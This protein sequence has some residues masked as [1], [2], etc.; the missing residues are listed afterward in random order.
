VNAVLHFSAKVYPAAL[1][2]RAQPYLDRLASPRPALEASVKVMRDRVREEFDGRQWFAP[3]GATVGWAPMVP[4][5]TKSGE[6]PPLIGTG[7]YPAAWQGVGPGAITQLTANSATIGVSGSVFKQ[8]GVLRGGTGPN[9]TTGPTLIRARKLT[10]GKRNWKGPQR[11]AMFWAILNLYGV[12]LSLD[13]LT[14]GLRVPGRPHATWHPE[15]HRRIVQAFRG[16][17]I[18]G[19]PY[20]FLAAA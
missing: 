14:Q 5:G 19:D 10:A 9:P 11:F 20:A 13:T 18:K 8:A 12:A 17:V 2:R 15:L 3:S 7:A 6:R 16:W 1:L 4:F